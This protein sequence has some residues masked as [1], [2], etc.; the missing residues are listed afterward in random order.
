M[1]KSTSKKLPLRFLNEM[2]SV[3]ISKTE[4]YLFSA[5][6]VGFWAVLFWLFVDRY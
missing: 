4:I 2:E 5:L 6:G 3:G 1:V